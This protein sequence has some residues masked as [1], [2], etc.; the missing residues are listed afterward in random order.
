M[1]GEKEFRKCCEERPS[2]QAASEMPGQKRPATDRRPD[3]DQDGVD[4]DVAA[5]VGLEVMPA[6]DLRDRAHLLA[7]ELRLGRF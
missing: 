4:E 2:P 3:D 5:D 6:L 1:I 7:V